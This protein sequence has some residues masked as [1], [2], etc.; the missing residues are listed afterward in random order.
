MVVAWVSIASERK[1]HGR[2]STRRNGGGGI[3]EGA[4]TGGSGDGDFLQGVDA[5]SGFA[6]V[7]E[8]FGSG[9]GGEAGGADC[10]WGDR[11]GGAE[12]GVLPRDCE[13]VA[14]IGRGRDAAGAIG[15]TGGNFP[16]A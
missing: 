15:K 9:G 7:D 5:G 1:I 8:Q 14:G 12:L 3:V 4:D 16:D 10:L 11:E 6:D 2:Y 13:V